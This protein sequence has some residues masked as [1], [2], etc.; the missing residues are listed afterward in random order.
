MKKWMLFIVLLAAIFLVPSMTQAKF[1]DVNYN[2]EMGRAIDF[3]QK[4]GVV[5]GFPNGTFQPY[6][7]VTRGQAAKMIGQLTNTVSM[8]YFTPLTAESH[9]KDVPVRHE[10]FPSIHGLLEYGA[11]GGYADGTFRIQQSV[12]RAHVSKMMANA[13]VLLAPTTNIAFTD[14]ARTNDRY[15]FA[16]R[17]YAAGIMPYKTFYPNKTVSRGEMALFLYRAYNKM[18]VD[19]RQAQTLKPFIGTNTTLG[20]AWNDHS[21]MDEAVRQRM[22]IGAVRQSVD[23]PHYYAGYE[24]PQPCSYFADEQFNI[25]YD[26]GAD[27]K[28]G[29]VT[30]FLYDYDMEHEV[31]LRTLKQALGQHAFTIETMTQ[32]NGQLLLM[33]YTKNAVNGLYYGFSAYGGPANAPFAQDAAIVR[34]MSVSLSPTVHFY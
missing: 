19:I 24:M 31:A 6:R 20:K 3:L 33:G 12:N 30:A 29:V 27:G 14:I 2:T 9:F 25:C 21:F 13:F 17:V 8:S 22:P 34:Q 23:E 10:Y 11:I 28:Y 32:E 4:E 5:Q 15:T 7:L 1:P 26:T 18:A 16:S